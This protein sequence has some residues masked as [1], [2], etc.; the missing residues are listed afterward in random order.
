MNKKILLAKGGLDGHDRGI[1][2]VA[3]ALRNA[4]FEVVYGGL[5][6]QPEQIAGM[7]IEE[8]VD[9][10]GISMLSGAH[11]G[12]FYE[13]IKILK[14]KT[15]EKWFLCG[16]GVIPEKDVAILEKM[17]V[18]KIF[19]PGTNTEDII[20]FA[21]EAE[22][23]KKKKESIKSLLEK[24]KKGETYAASRLM[25]L[26]TRGTDREKQKILKLPDLPKETF[27]IGVT[28]SG[29]VGKSTLIDKLIYAF[30]Q[31]NKTVGVVVCDP[32]SISGGAVLGDRIRMQDHALDEGVF[33]RSLVQYE[34]FKAVTPE[35]PYIVKIFG[36]MKKDVVIIETV[37]VGQSDLGFKDLVKTLIWVSIPG[38]GD[39]I[40]LLKGGVVET[41]DIIVVNQ[42]D[43]VG[44]DKSLQQFLASFGNTKKIYKTNSV[45]GEGIAELVKEIKEAHS[46]L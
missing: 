25:T 35:V 3:R 31:E 8:D 5:Y 37:G 13:T 23:V 7:A 45:T 42:S 20:N 15:G 21:L 34:N 6:C 32:A 41:A 30:R 22:A 12:V 1:Q 18:K 19:L 9:M 11:I 10:I 38:L 24:V 2:V 4:G 40:Q 44:A 16:G 29:G 28:G 46:G 36:A 33:I 14:E 39:E 26:A 43:K 27:L 17:G